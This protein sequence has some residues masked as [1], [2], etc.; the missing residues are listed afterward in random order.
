MSVV[1]L[2]NISITKMIKIATYFNI[3]K[4]KEMIECRYA[5]LEIDRGYLK[6]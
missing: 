6:P 2:Y 4:N 5:K 1:K 3:K